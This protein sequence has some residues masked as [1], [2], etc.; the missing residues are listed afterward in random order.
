MTCYQAMEALEGMGYQFTITAEGKIR[1]TLHGKQ[2]PEASALLAI[3]KND[4]ESAIDY[5]ERCSVFDAVVI[6]QAVKDGEARLIGKVIY[7]TKR[8]NVTIRWKPLNGQSRSTMLNTRREALKAALEDRVR[9]MDA[10][11][12]RELTTE[13]IDRLNAE[14]GRCLLLLKGYSKASAKVAQESA[15]FARC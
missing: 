8:N 10:E 14:Y 12:D 6:G 11:L 2:L 4:R 7:H 5:L 1:G 15:Y 13:E 9:A 3:V